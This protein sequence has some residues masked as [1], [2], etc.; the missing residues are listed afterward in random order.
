MENDNNEL[1]TNNAGEGAG[2]IK[3]LC[4]LFPLL[5]LILYLVWQS[6]K[7]AAANECGKFALIGVAVSIGLGILSFIV[8]MAMISSMY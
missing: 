6:D 4:L 5:G 3:W 8:S 7:P 2:G 1:N